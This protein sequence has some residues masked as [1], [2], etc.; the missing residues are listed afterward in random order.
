MK[1]KNN[2][3]FESRCTCGDGMRPSAYD[4][5]CPIDGLDIEDEWQEEIRNLPCNWD[6]TNIINEGGK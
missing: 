6:I 5:A 3:E 4:P 2:N 1:D